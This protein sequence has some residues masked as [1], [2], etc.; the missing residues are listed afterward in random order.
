M[1]HLETV[2]PDT[3]V[4]DIAA[5]K[6]EAIVGRGRKKDFI[7]IAFLLEHFPLNKMLG[8]YQKKYPAG[9]KYLVMR[10]LVYFDYA[11]ENPMPVMLKPLSWDE[12][13]ERICKAVRATA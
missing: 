12:A 6:L 1:L 13:K 4:E 3:L 11:E 8:M 10:S 5:M 9:L 7:D 2:S